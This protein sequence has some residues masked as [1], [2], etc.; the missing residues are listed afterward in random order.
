MSSP[1]GKGTIIE[2]APMNRSTIVRVPYEHSDIPI[3]GLLLTI[4]GTTSD[5]H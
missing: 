2:V 4:L 1:P 5:L 3:V